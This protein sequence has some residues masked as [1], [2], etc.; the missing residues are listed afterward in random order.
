MTEQL[1]SRGAFVRDDNSVPITGLGLIAPK[2]ITYSALTTGA[3]GT[4]TLFTVTGTVALT[5]FAIAS[6]TDLTGLGTIEVGIAGNTAALIAQTAATAIDDG[7]F[8]YD[9]TPVTVGVM[10]AQKIVNVDVIQTIATNTVTAG[11]LTYYCLWTP[12]ST[13]GNVVAA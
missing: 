9:G 3:V 12:V 4:T 11:T 1:T 8:W 5:I 7:E 10:P 6:G 13:N 2:A